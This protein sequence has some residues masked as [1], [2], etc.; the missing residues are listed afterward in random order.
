MTLHDTLQHAAGWS[1]LPL[2]L[3]P[4]EH[5]LV[6]GWDHRLLTSEDGRVLT[7]SYGIFKPGGRLRITKHSTGRHL[8]TRP[9]KLSSR[10]FVRN[11]DGTISPCAA[12]SLV[13]GVE[14][15]PNIA[16]SLP[17]PRLR[18]NSVR[19][20]SFQIDVM[21]PSVALE[22]LQRSHMP[23]YDALE[24]IVLQIRERLGNWME[25]KLAL[26]M[27]QAQDTTMGELAM[28]AG[29]SQHEDRHSRTAALYSRSATS[30]PSAEAEPDEEST[31]ANALAKAN[32]QQVLLE[33]CTWLLRGPGEQVKCTCQISFGAL[34]D[35][36]GSPQ[37]R[38]SIVSI[39]PLRSRI[40]NCKAHGHSSSVVLPSTLP[41]GL[42]SAS[43]ELCVALLS[44]VD[45]YLPMSSDGSDEQKL[46]DALLHLASDPQR[47]VTAAIRTAPPH[48]LRAVPLAH[49]L[50]PRIWG[51]STVHASAKSNGVFAFNA[52]SFYSF[53]H[54]A[55]TVNWFVSHAWPDEST[56]KL[57][58]LRFFLCVVD[59]LGALMVACPLLAIYFAPVGFAVAG[60]G[61]RGFEWWMLPMLP[62]GV[63]FA[64]CMWIA[65]SYAG[66]MPLA[67]TPW[68]MSSTTVWIGAP[69]V[70]QP[71]VSLHDEA[72]HVHVVVL[73]QTS[74]A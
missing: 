60:L 15:E 37:D 56:S 40:L 70:Q 20:Q 12:P 8:Q 41:Q 47:E 44:A 58:L 48:P 72:E 43:A 16:A 25:W 3:G 10:E 9:D 54:E 52:D 67:L 73:R 39:E 66:L 32:A 35:M 71:I 65:L 21:E 53:S 34:L 13:L 5:A 14:F 1:S 57:A 26:H 46:S 17:P 62:C 24:E 36:T 28:V 55:E 68:S 59:L 22:L 38:A 50:D 2:A 18:R 64:A 63:L 27:S 42:R 6:A 61:I 23:L 69:A 7:V 51:A 31:R 49:G 19:R 74:A 11:N 29:W 30:P 33:V 45:D 4:T